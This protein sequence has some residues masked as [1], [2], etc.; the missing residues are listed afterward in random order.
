MPR[1][2]RQASD[3]RFALKGSGG[4]QMRREQSSIRNRRTRQRLSLFIVFAV[5]SL[6]GY[7]WTVGISSIGAS[8]SFNDPV[9]P[10]EPQDLDYSRFAHSSPTHTRMPC[11]LCHRRDTNASRI[12]FPGKS[13][14]TPCI[15]C[16]QQQFAGSGSPI[17]T[18][19][20]TNAANGAMKGFPK[21]H[22]GLT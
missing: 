20:H 3:T 13:G 22:G 11:L 4:C 7:F 10:T 21:F 5:I 18:I 8:T 19:C 12:N 14:H 9:T 6:F 16:H 2:V 1:H 15:G 17:C